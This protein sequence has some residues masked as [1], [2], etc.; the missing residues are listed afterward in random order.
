ME[1]SGTSPVAS[2]SKSERAE[3]IVTAV[4]VKT[5]VATKYW[6]ELKQYFPLM[7]R[8]LWLWVDDEWRHLDDPDPGTQDSVQDAFCQCPDHLEVAVW[9]RG[10]VIVG[11]VVRSK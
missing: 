3:E 2:A 5:G 10:K 1:E 4:P 11:L 9:Y 8:S 7:A 6:L